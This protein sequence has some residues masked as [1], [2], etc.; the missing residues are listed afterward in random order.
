MDSINTPGQ[1][2]PVAAGHPA[3][4]RGCL[5]TTAWRWQLPL[6]VTILLIMAMP[7]ATAAQHP[8]TLDATV[9]YLITYVQ[10]ADVIFER[11]STRYDGHEAAVH[12]SKKYRHFKDEIDTPETFIALCAT[13][14]LLTGK[15]YIVTMKQGVQLPAGEWLNSALAVYRH[16][17][18]SVVP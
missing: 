16:R 7:R 9:Q 15:P 1:R 18:E 5:Q 10:E 14:S 12:I 13:G 2:M 17:H 8:D 11:N 4:L 3:G 6:L